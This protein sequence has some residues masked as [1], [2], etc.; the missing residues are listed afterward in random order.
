ML[1]VIYRIS[2]ST[3][4]KI[5]PDYVNNYQCLH[6][7]INAFPLDYCDWIVV[8][9]SISYETTEM[10]VK[11]ISKENIYHIESKSGPGAPFIYALDKLI[12][13]VQDSDIIYFLENDYIH[14]PNSYKIIKEGINLGADYVSLYDHPDKYIDGLNPFIEGGGEYTKVF[15]SNSVHWKLT[16]STTGTFAATRKTIKRDYHI[17]K[18]YASKPF[19]S[20]FEMFI[21]LRDLGRSLITPIPGYSTHGETQ[22]LSPLINWEKYADSNA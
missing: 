11:V 14:R 3:F 7:A 19:W 18:K 2:E 8:A 4:N 15:L 1:R 22:W 17:L 21:E 10:I 6:N 16:N 5:K 9:D 12:E 13:D 20:D